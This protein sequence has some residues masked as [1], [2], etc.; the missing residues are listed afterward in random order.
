MGDV[1]RRRRLVLIVEIET[2]HEPLIEPVQ[3]ATYL[4]VSMRTIQRDMAKGALA[5]KRIGSAARKRIKIHV[6]CEYAGVQYVGP[7]R[8]SV[9]SNH[10]RS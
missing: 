10:D 5:Y 4:K 7:T 1:V 9:V 3:L 2:H 6:A 8:R